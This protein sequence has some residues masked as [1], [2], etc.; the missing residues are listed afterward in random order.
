MALTTW[1]GRIVRKQD[2]LIAFQELPLLKGKGSI[3]HEAMSEQIHTRFEA[4]DARR[5]QLDAQEADR[6]DLAELEAL[7][8]QVKQKRGRKA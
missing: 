1:Q 6:Q 7:E 2:S 3:S 5:K 8:T 4:F